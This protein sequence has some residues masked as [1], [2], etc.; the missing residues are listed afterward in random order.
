MTKLI[1]FQSIFFD[2]ILQKGTGATCMA[3]PMLAS[4]SRPQL[5]FQSIYSSLGRTV[6]GRTVG[7]RFAAPGSRTW[8]W[9][10]G[11]NLNLEP[12]SIFGNKIVL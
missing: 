9:A 3:A 1:G 10:P 11:S 8:S 12:D 7:S 2:A 6:D 5:S 4:R